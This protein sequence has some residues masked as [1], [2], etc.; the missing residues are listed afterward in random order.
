MKNIILQHFHPF[1]PTVIQ[2]MKERNGLPFIVEKSVKNISRY[3][4]SLGA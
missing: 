3:A 2:E 1:R 4:E